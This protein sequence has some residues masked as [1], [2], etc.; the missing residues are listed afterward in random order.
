MD[1]VLAGL[2]FAF[3]YR[4]DFFIASSSMEQHQQDI[5]EVFRLL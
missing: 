4:D 5:E 2:A 3:V 1:R